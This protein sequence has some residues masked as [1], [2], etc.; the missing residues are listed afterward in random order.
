MSCWSTLDSR[1]CAPWPF[2]TQTLRQHPGWSCTN[3]YQIP[4]STWVKM[5]NSCLADSR[6]E[7]AKPGHEGLSKTFPNAARLLELRRLLCTFPRFLLGGRNRRASRR[8]R[9]DGFDPAGKA[10]PRGARRRSRRAPRPPLNRPRP[11]PSAPPPPS[12]TP[13]QPQS[14]CSKHPTTITAAPPAPCGA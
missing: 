2:R 4:C 13:P 12:P 6:F 5:V 14:S 1:A 11:R 8:Q 10:A 3:S 7:G 9:A